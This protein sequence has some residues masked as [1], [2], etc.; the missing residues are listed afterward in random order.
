MEQFNLE[1][2]L[3]DK[4][5]KVV[6]RDGREV[7]ILKT[8]FRGYKQIIGVIKNRDNKDDE[9]EQWDGQGN[10]RG[11]F[12]GGSKYDLFFADE[13]DELTE[14][15]KMLQY[16]LECYSGHEFASESEI[17]TLKLNAQS[18]LNLARKQLQPEFEAELDKAYKTADNV[19]YQKGKQDVLKDLPK[20]KRATENK[21]CCKH[22]LLLG[23]EERVV[24]AT[25]I[26]E[27]ELYIAM[28]DLKTLPKEE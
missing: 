2:W 22:V 5:R 4:S 9:V 25:E 28:D 1:K 12:G 7:E 24:F 6:T 17:E 13:K 8:D 27:G 23:N 19:Q 15:E 26:Y 18:L 11:L 21:G 10:F 14:F 20:W 16:V 3:Q